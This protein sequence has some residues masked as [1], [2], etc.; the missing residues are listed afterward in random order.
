MITATNTPYV[1][2]YEDRTIKVPVQTKTG[3]EYDERTEKVVSNPIDKRYSNDGS[4][5][6][7]RK[8]DTP[9]FQVNRKGTRMVIH[10]GQFGATAFKPRIQMIGTK[11]ILHYDRKH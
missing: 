6:R 10:K 8:S 11:A 4:N 3:I 9:R 5:R 1:K 2:K 7:N